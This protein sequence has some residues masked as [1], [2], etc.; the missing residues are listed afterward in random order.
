[1][2]CRYWTSRP[3]RSKPSSTCCSLAR[4][5]G[6]SSHSVIQHASLA[7]SSNHAASIEIGVIIEVL[8]NQIQHASRVIGRSPLLNLRRSL[9][10]LCKLWRCPC[11]RRCHTACHTRLSLLQDASRDLHLYY[12]FK[13]RLATSL[14]Y[15]VAVHF[16]ASNTKRLL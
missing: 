4:K 16:S 12:T 10:S 14:P 9:Y 8:L 2:T 6:E 1:V 7:V 15:T 3:K 11:S 5:R 13:L